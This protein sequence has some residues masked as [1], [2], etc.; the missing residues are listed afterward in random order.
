MKKFLSLILAVCLLAVSLC[1]CKSEEEKRID[2]YNKL[3]PIK[4]GVSVGKVPQEEVIG[5]LS[6]RM[7]A[8]GYRIEYVEFKNAASANE[9]L[10]S[11]DIDIS[12]ICEKQ[13]FDEY[14]K[15]NPDV[16]LNLG[17]VYYF[18]YGIFLCNFEKEENITDGATIGIP[19]DKEGMGRAL[20]LLEAEGYITLKEGAGLDA[21]LEDIEK[22]ERGFK[23]VTESADTI[24]ENIVSGGKDIVVMSSKNAVDAG[25]SFNKTAIGAEE[26]DCEGAK[27]HSTLLLIKRE[28]IS[29]E[30]Y[31]AVSKLYFSPLMYDMIESYVGGLIIPSF[32][33]ADYMNKR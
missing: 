16:L 24:A 12:L 22:N 25:Y 15:T 13:E 6:S 11:G 19:E 30:K 8:K 21:T 29:S 3:P 17:A 1:A 33:A 20:M 23:F 18:P 31:K 14:E 9:A 32:N 2:E 27:V 7:A 10:A 28:S 5:E 26:M 4:F